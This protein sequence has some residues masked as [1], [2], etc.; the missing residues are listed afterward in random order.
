M[1]IIGSPPGLRL[2]RDR[3]ERTHVNRSTHWIIAVLLLAVLGAAAVL[4]L[5]LT[6]RGEGGERVGYAEVDE[7]V[8]AASGDDAEVLAGADPRRASGEEGELALEAPRFLSGTVRSSRG[9][10]VPG[11][12]VRV[13][14]EDGTIL[15]VQTDRGGEYTLANLPGTARS[16][17]VLAQGF[18]TRVFEPLALPA[19][20][21]VT[22]DVTLE[23]MEGIW[24][25]VLVGD[26]PVSGATVS[27]AVVREG[28]QQV[29]T[30]D[31]GRFS[32][33]W[34]AEGG[35][36]EVVAQHPIHGRAQKVIAGPGEV[37]IQL[38]G[39]GHVSGRVEDDRG[40]PVTHFRL[41][42]HGAEGGRGS[43]QGFQDAR[44]EFKIGPL[45]PGPLQL[46]AFAEGYQLSRGQPL[47]LQAGQDLSG[48][49]LVLNA[50]GEVFGRITDATTG[51]PIPNA[52]V[53]PQEYGSSGAARSAVAVADGSGNYRLTTVPGHRTSL[54]VRAQGYQPLLGGGVDA[55]HGV[56]VRRDFA[57]TP[58]PHGERPRGQLTGIGAVLQSTPEG[59]AIR[60]LVE[61]GPAE[62][63]LKAG[64]VV[65][66]VGEEDMRGADLGRAAQAIRGEEGTDVELWIQRGDGQ[67]TKVVIRRS[68][69][70]F[71][72][73]KP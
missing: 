23:P 40:S 50:S 46:A 39:G 70:S 52:E 41:S 30:D 58:V 42:W 35:T 7:E 34:P 66:R 24:G 15:S 29:R 72:G 28:Y 38:P 11:A 61:G 10:V 54:A 2:Q 16:M 51:R 71:P 27:L 13:A 62:G 6:R 22:F 53:I 3:R 37:A 4:V 33:P 1:I 47:T 18:F 63:Y 5:V 68:V 65:V 14:M 45:S 57:L 17:E 49:V 32:M 55:P 19:S 43:E 48:V 36:V 67:P 25:V 9:P 56:R 31:A 73:G 21:R 44:G 12:E 20:A 26:E 60:N 64:D 59:V 69:V 8:S